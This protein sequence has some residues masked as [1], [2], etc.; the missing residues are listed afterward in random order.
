MTDEWDGS[1]RRVADKRLAVSDR[2]LAAAIAEVHEL[3]EA[4]AKLAEAVKVRTSEFRRVVQQVAVMLAV[5]LVIL[6]VFFLWQGARLN[7]RID[8]G[9]DLITCLLLVDPASR[10]AQ[11]L[12]DCQR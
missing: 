12:I 2:R 10:T 1:E 3:R 7:Q 9:H 4:A 11:T 8:H 5:L 6:V